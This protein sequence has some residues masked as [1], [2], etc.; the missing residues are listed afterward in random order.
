MIFQRQKDAFGFSLR[1]E[2]FFISEPE[3]QTYVKGQI[4]AENFVPRAHWQARLPLGIDNY[5]H[6]DGI[7][8]IGHHTH[9]DR[10]FDIVDCI[11]EVKKVQDYHMDGNGWWDVGYNF[12][13]GEDGRIYEGRGFHIQ[14]EISLLG[15]TEN[16]RFCPVLAGLGRFWLV[17]AGPGRSWPVLAG[18]GRSWPVLVG[19][20]RSWPVLAGLG[21]SWPVLAG[22]EISWGC[23]AILLLKKKFGRPARTDQ[24][25]PRPAKT[26]Q[27]RPFLV[28]PLIFFLRYSPD[29][30][31]RCPLLWLEH[32]NTWFHNNGQFHF[33][34]S[35][36][37]SS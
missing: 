33:R 15:V 2:L 37:P 21:R 22:L 16:G 11:K 19:L 9:W 35:K 12:L 32:P 27:N 13:I 24:D 23:G 5:F 34:S 8:V 29:K 3:A 30:I 31:L 14:G 7:G 20:G 4:W 10:C 26:S 18:P 25:R 1:S 17:L 6:H 28:P 36:Q